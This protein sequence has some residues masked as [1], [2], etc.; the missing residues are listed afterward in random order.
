MEIANAVPGVLGSRMTGGG[1]G[2]CTITLVRAEAVSALISSLTELY[3][4]TTGK[5]C[6]SYVVT[7]S[8]GSG[9]INC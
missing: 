6:I 4:S 1:F 9:A 3:R 2:G 5:D 7:P 8:A